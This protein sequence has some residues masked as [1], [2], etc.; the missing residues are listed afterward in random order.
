L[1]QRQ[2]SG[3]RAGMAPGRSAS[4]GEVWSSVALVVLTLTYLHLRSE[5]VRRAAAWS[6]PP[7]TETAAHSVDSSDGSAQ[8]HPGSLNHPTGSMPTD[9]VPAHHTP[10]AEPTPLWPSASSPQA[11]PHDA[12]TTAEI[13][14]LAKLS[15]RLRSADA[16]VAAA[17]ATTTSAADAKAETIAA[18]GAVRGRSSVQVPSPAQH[19]HASSRGRGRSGAF[20]R[21]AVG[22]A[23]RRQ[24]ALHVSEDPEENWL[25]RGETCTHD[26][27]TRTHA[28]AHTTHTH[29]RTHT[30]TH[31]HTHTLISVLMSHS[32]SFQLMIFP[33]LKFI[34]G[35]LAP[36]RVC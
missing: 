5:Q 3:V 8:A 17:A 35:S 19:P 32:T 7:A 18:E 16:A 33:L 21:F 36:L 12:T 10:P 11:L 24:W 25:W 15:L 14:A 22:D 2:R 23:A 27:H 30:R 28:H 34:V 6:P 1:G 29:T 20:D 13:A 31:T 4:T 9:F 26:T